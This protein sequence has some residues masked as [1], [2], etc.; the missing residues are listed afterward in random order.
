MKLPLV[1]Q[2]SSSSSGWFAAALSR[3]NPGREANRDTSSPVD[4]FINE[5]D[6]DV[7]GEVTS[8][9]EPP[10]EPPKKK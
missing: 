2:I 7:D 3:L 1:R 6:D 4:K 10:P 8:D 9:E 5:N